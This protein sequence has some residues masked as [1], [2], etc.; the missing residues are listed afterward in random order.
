MKKIITSLAVVCLLFNTACSQATVNSAVKEIN[1][2]ALQV[3][4]KDN[5]YIAM[6]KCG[7]PVSYPNI[8]YE[9]AFESFF[10]SPKWINGTTEDGK[11]VVEFS[12]DC[13]YNDVTV[14]ATIQFLLDLDNNTFTSEYLA[15]N[16]VPQNKLLLNTLIDEAFSQYA[17]ENS[18]SS[19]TTQ[20]ILEN[21]TSEPQDNTNIST[22]TPVNNQTPQTEVNEAEVLDADNT[23]VLTGAIDK[24]PI[25][26]TINFD[27]D[28]TSVGSYYYDEFGTEIPFVG[29]I[30]GDYMELYVDTADGEE[31]FY[32][33]LSSSDYTG[34]WIK[35]DTSLDFY[36]T[37]Q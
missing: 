16:D 7:V 8:T 3:L 5:E 1:D 2:S 20:P 9:Q 29:Y 32:G 10:A 4:D 34:T 35:G 28:T 37:A 15:F 19:T 25:H 22:E 26:M 23:F 11:Q 31:V 21:T 33:T 17:G 14:K 18:N 24:Y 12:G 13:T 27:S 30:D 6:V 36:V